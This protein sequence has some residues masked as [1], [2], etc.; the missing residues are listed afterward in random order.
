M[1][2]GFMSIV[3]ASLVVHEL[4]H[5]YVAL[6]LGDTTAQRAGRLTLNPLAHVSPLLTIVVPVAT[7]LL[8]GGA[9]LIGGGKPIPVNRHQLRHGWAGYLAVVLAG[10][11]SNLALAALAWS[12]GLDRVVMAN[13]ALALINLLPLPYLDGGNAVR[14]VFRLTK[15]R[16]A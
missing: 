9:F 12:I 2:L 5:G 3:F 14:A 13:L 6:W 10:P 15:E 1:T 4:A 8:S 16:V 11:A 7:W